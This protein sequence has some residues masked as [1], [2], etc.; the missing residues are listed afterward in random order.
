M[1]APF[2][3]RRA[4]GAA[5]AESLTATPSSTEAKTSAA[6]GKARLP[7][8][9]IVRAQL[10]DQFNHP[11]GGLVRGDNIRARLEGGQRIGHRDRAPADAQ[12]GVVVFRIP[13]GNAIVGR[14]AQFAEGTT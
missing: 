14:N 3:L 4:S 2:P 10:L 12:K 6:T 7:T 13:D 11:V 8:A 9:Q 5:G 1:P